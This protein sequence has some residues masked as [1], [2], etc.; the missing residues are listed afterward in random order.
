[1]ET[2]LKKEFELTERQQVLLEFVKEQHGEQKRK[3]TNEPYWTHPLAVAALIDKYGTQSLKTFNGIEIALCHDL[4]EDT[5][6]TL[7]ILKEKLMEIGYSGANA[8]QISFSVNQLSDT[9]TPERYRGMNRKLRKQNEAERL[10]EISGVAQTIKYADLIDN[11]S[12]IVEHDAGFART[13][14]T[15]KF[16]ILDKMRN[17]EIRLFILC[18]HTFQNAAN[19][20]KLQP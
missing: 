2:T 20:I 4:Y 5:G 13:Y 17:G 15:E 12:S 7:N 6:C 10:G 16:E 1:M 18:C 3:Y 19:K 8:F 14:L 9:F 11:T